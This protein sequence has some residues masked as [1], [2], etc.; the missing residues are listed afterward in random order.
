MYYF[1]FTI[2]YDGT[3]YCGWA[4]QVGQ[5]TIQGQLEKAIAQVAPNS[6]YRVVGAS[7]TDS[8]VHARD[9]KAWVELDFN[10]NLTGFLNAINKTLGKA[11]YIKDAKIIE[12]DFRVRSC[13]QKTY[14][15]NINIGKDNVFINRFMFD[16]K[17]QM[18][19]NKLKEAFNL[20]IGEHD[21]LNFSGLKGKELD[22]IET[23]RKITSIEVIEKEDKIKII[24]KAKG[25]IR[26]QIR[27]MVGAA[28]AYNENKIDLKTI[29][30]VLDLKHQRLPY[31]A[32]PE[33]LVLEK[34]DY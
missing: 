19:V 16:Y 8:G 21:F 7:K 5:S 20:F 22:L 15:Y 34:I 14:H 10:P 24:F 3:D 9:Q 6:H 2:E 33:G 23:R 26:Y 28:L 25:F 12:K 30:A 4:K 29:E 31:N 13:I 27:M 32:K 1:L 17:K 18:D 11:I